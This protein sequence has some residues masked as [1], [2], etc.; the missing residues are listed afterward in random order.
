MKENQQTHHELT[1]QLTEITETMQR[2]RIEFTPEI[3]SFF[4]EELAKLNDKLAKGEPVYRKDLDFIEKLK[5]W[6]KMPKELREKYSSIEAMQAGS[7]ELA[8]EMLLAKSYDEMAD[9]LRDFEYTDK[10]PAKQKVMEAIYNLGPEMLKKISEFKL[11]TIIMTP[12]VKLNKMKKYLDKNKKYPD[13]KD[14]HFGLPPDDP[15]WGATPTRFSVSIVDG[16]PKINQLPGSN[17]IGEYYDFLAEEYKKN[18]FRM[19][20][21]SEYM[22][23]AQKSLRSYEHK[24]NPDEIIDK[25]LFTTLELSKNKISELEQIPVASW[26]N[27]L[28]RFEFTWA[29]PD[30]EINTLSGRPSIQIMEI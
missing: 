12:P 29:Q 7:I 6:I 17:Y 11:P 9:T 2:E 23:L 21:A 5:Q 8:T 14:T 30:N 24:H 19:I 20:T 15:L 22:M 3:Q 27:S 1:A 10:I 13:Q 26:S 18:G 28:H 16:A 25:T 4:E